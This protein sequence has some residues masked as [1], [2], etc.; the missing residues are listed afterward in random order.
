MTEKMIFEILNLAFTA[1][2]AGIEKNA[3]EAH[4][5]EME[6]QGATQAEIAAALRKMRDDAIQKAAKA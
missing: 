2:A 5:R 3:V 1:V 4:V 6:L